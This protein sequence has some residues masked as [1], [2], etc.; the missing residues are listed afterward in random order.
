MHDSLRKESPAFYKNISDGAAFTF[1]YL[2]LKKGGSLESDIGEAFA[3]LC[4]VRK[5]NES[6]VEAGRII[7]KESAAVIENEI[8]N[9][10]LSA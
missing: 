1:Y 8:K 7:W 6:F 9:A 4:S 10:Q 3:M 5:D 2:A